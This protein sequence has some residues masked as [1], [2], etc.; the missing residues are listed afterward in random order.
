MTIFFGYDHFVEK[1]TLS[2]TILMVDR[3]AFDI[4]DE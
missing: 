3:D 1:F 4:Q 2:H